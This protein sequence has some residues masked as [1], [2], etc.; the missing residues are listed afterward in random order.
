MSQQVQTASSIPSIDEIGIS[1]E[2]LT[3][4]SKPVSPLPV[5]RREGEEALDDWL[6]RLPQAN[7]TQVIAKSF[8]PH[9]AGSP[10]PDVQAI[11]YQLLRETGSAN[12]LEIGTL[13]AGS[14]HVLARAAHAVGNGTVVTIDP[15]GGDRV[16]AILQELPT[17]LSGMVHFYPYNSMELFLK[18]L[19]AQIEFDAVFIDG[20]HSYAGAHFDLFSAAQCVKPNGL[21]VMDNTNE[22]GVTHAALEFIERFPNW[23]VLGVSSND[24]ERGYEMKN[25]ILQSLGTAQ[26]Y[27]IKPAGTSLGKFPLKFHV[28]PPNCTG[29]NELRLHLTSPSVPGKLDFRG[30]LLARHHDFHLTGTGVERYLRLGTHVVEKGLSNI[31]IPVEPVRFEADS[32]NH[33]F[34]LVLEF[35]F[36]ADTAGEALELDGEPELQFSN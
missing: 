5:A 17:E 20:D 15:F 9:S 8:E 22:S 28:N 12:I 4:L 34:E 32:S 11:M 36:I 3:A 18:N 19:Q 2:S 25:G 10:L 21:I 23:R 24:I 27:M 6:L 35:Q 7:E 31:R 16:P 1:R 26:L 29:G 33:N 14:T 30:Q 13:F